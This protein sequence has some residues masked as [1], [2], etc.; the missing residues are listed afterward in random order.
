MG[1]GQHGLGLLLLDTGTAERKGE[2]LAAAYRQDGVEQTNW[3]KNVYGGQTKIGIQRLVCRLG[4]DFWMTN[5]VRAVFVHPRVK[6]GHIHITYLLPLPSHSMQG[7]SASS[8]PQK[9]LA[10]FQGCDQIEGSQKLRY[11]G[12]VVDQSLLGNLMFL[13]VQPL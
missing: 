7:H 10:G 2:L 9:G 12:L 6:E 3:R 11:S 13:V 1:S 4:D 5:G 8:S